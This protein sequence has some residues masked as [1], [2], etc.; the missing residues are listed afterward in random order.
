MDINNQQF[1][2][3]LRS[4]L[5][6]LYDPDQLRRSPLTILF[7][8]SDRMDASAVLQK[9]LLEAI[10]DLKPGDDEPPQ[11][12]SWVVYDVLFFRYVRGYTREAVAN[13]LG[14]SD[15]QFSREQRSAIET[16][17]VS[18]WKTYGLENKPSPASSAGDEAPPLDDEKMDDSAWVENLPVE[19]PSA[20][21]PVIQSV[22]ELVQPLLDQHAVLL[23]YEPEDSLAAQVVPQYTLRHALL[24]IL[25]LLIPLAKGGSLL[26][27]PT[28]QDQQLIIKTER[29]LSE[30][31]EPV[32]EELTRNSGLQVANQLVEH[33]G[34]WLTIENGAGFA[35]ITIAIPVL[36]QIPVLVID[37]NAD[38][39]Q[40][41]Q[42]YAQGTRFSVICTQNPEEAKKLVETYRPRIVLLDLMMPE[43]DGW[44]LLA[45][46]RQMHAPSQM[47][48]VICSI[49]PQ[50]SLARALGASGFLQ[51]P[52]LPQDFLNTL[53]Q[54]LKGLEPDEPT[55]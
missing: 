42:R 27:I 30:E 17:A 39:L 10:E 55:P 29:I 4:A 11:S 18:L 26:L 50:E 45:R 1:T 19:K 28:L 5:H 23:E 43:V 51:K 37:D 49:L 2:T 7:S 3:Y 8:I 40:L 47:A 53:E 22:L 46:L 52:V 31:V 34:G 41:F 21:I 35:M 24:N 25:G 48:L 32:Q 20:W 13:Q 44:E 33:A 9:M 6:Y 15:R 36:E 54:Q 14:I 12:R 38:T 16:L